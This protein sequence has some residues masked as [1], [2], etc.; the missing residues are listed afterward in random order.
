[1]SLEA[2]EKKIREDGKAEAERIVAEAESDR[3][4]ALEE[5]RAEVK[6][7]LKEEH[8]KLK[9][10]MSSRRERLEAHERR[11]AEQRIQ[12]FRRGLIDDAVDA[13]VER[14]AGLETEEYRRLAA[15]LLDGCGLEGEVEVLTAPGDSERIDQAFLDEHSTE[16]RQF[17]L[18]GET[19][20]GRGG[21]VF[22]SGRISQNATFDMI[23][24]LAH[25][26]LVMELSSKIPLESG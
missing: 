3:S 24:D 17:V 5:K 18:S 8:R 25:D 21:F 7:D 10:R 23:A 2:I 20:G 14:L 12:N 19:H 22:R 1:M 16:S 11:Q 26:R 6:A 4:R 15:A 13:A 9:Q